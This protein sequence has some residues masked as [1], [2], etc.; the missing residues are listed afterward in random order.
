MRFRVTIL[1]GGQ[2]V[3]IQELDALDEADA[4]RQALARGLRVLGIQAA[5]WRG[6][7][8]ARL[9]LVVFSNELIAL[10]EAGLSLVG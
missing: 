8:G 4:Q 9:P 3:A 6:L 5:R 2:G 7:R 1:D 10:L